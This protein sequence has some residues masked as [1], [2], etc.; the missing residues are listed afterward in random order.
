M[1]ELIM[2]KNCDG[3]RIVIWRYPDGH[4]EAQLLGPDGKH[5]CQGRM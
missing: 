5:V 4:N 1:P 2:V 3:W